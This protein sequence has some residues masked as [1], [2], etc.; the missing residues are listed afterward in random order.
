M[1]DTPGIPVTGRSENEMSTDTVDTV[2][3][4]GDIDQDCAELALE[5][6]VATH[7]GVMLDVT[8]NAE[9]A[10]SIVRYSAARKFNREDPIEAA[11]AEV[12]LKKA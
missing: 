9:G 11:A 10:S 5:S 2:D 7:E 8:A 12:I 6:M 3:N 1:P 4:I